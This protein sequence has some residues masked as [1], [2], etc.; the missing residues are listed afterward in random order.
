MSAW[1][2]VPCLV[3]LREEFNA[4]SPSRD[5]G[6]DGSIGDRVHSPASDHSADEDSPILRDHDADSKNEVHAV[7]IDSTGPWPG[8]WNWFD[9][10]VHSIVDRERKRWLDPN[11]MCRLEYVIWDG[12]I[13]SRSINDF[14]WRTYT[15]SNDPHTGHAHFSARY[16]TVAENDTSP[17]GISEEEMTPEQIQEAVLTVL[18]SAEGQ[19][20]IAKAAGRGV[21]NQKLGR[22]DVTIGQAVQRTDVNVSKLAEEGDGTVTQPTQP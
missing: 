11:D 9:D 4:V 3:T 1:V 10:A 16:L 5:K 6:S 15:G 13:A 14:R 17:Y 20:A 21:H 18:E 12:M 7:D 19:A 22:T 2:L 8:G